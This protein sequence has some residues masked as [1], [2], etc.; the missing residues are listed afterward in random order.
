MQACGADVT[1]HLWRS[2][3]VAKG[4]GGV[5]GIFKSWGDQLELV[6]LVSQSLKLLLQLLSDGEGVEYAMLTVCAVREIVSNTT[7]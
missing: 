3:I 5:T 1:E 2:E 6:T 7:L 4:M